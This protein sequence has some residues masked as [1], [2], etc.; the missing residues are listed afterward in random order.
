MYKTPIINNPE[1]LDKVLGEVQ[2]GLTNNLPWL[3]YAFGRA[4]RL[5]KEIRKRKHYIPGVYSGKNDYLEVSP[6][7][8][9]GNFSFFKIEDPQLMDWDPKIRGR[10]KADFSLIFWFDLRK[11]EGTQGRNTEMVKAQILKAL[12]GGFPIR[13]GRISI[14][15]IYEEAENIYKGYSIQEVDNQFLMHPYAGF[16]FKGT[17]TINE[18][19]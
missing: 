5:V 14:S 1:L 2:K 18:S 19:C 8:D 6:D 12:N 11:I 9:I 7:A 13:N 4:Q 3:N 15:R 17:L 10:I 16:R